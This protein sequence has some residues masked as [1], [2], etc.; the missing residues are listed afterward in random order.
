MHCYI[1]ENELWKGGINFHL[2]IEFQDGIVWLARIC[3]S[4]ATSLPPA[5]RDYI[6][7]SEVATL[8][9]LKDTK[10]P[11]L[12]VFCFTFK[13]EENNKVGVRYIS[14]KKMLGKPL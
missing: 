9:F 14:Y 1:L 11:T 8:R 6:I 5:L 4:N 10:I 3:R 13:D 12:K 2:V 7:R